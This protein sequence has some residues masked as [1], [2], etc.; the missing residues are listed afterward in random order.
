MA[1]NGGRGFSISSNSLSRSASTRAP[2]HKTTSSGSSSVG[3]GSRMPSASVARPKSSYGTHNRSKSHYQRPATSMAQREPEE[4][5][6]PQGGHPF[7]V[8]TDPKVS[9]SKLVIQ[10]NSSRGSANRL[11]SLNVPPK[12]LPIFHQRSISS[13]SSLRPQ[14]S[15]PATPAD[16][17]CDDILNRFGALTLGASTD[18]GRTSRIGRGNNAGKN[19]DISFPSCIPRSTPSRLMLPPPP[20]P[21][22]APRSPRRPPTPMTPFLNKFTNDRVPVFDDTRVASLEAQ[23]TAWKEQM[24][25]DMDK[26]SK[27]QE[28]I[29][30]Y[31][32]KSTCNSETRLA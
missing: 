22:P 26:Q 21:V 28:S 13:P 23:F 18:Q 12:R 10:K 31:K 1:T 20:P 17:D 5:P 25:Q 6:E 30:L 3:H 9:L 7:S 29:E 14:A 24:V 15:E 11:Y 4:R 32:T 27:V 16:T 19:L 2:T 8:S